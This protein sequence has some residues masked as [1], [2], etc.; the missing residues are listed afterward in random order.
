[1]KGVGLHEAGF[2][3]LVGKNGP[4]ALYAEPE[5]SLSGRPLDIILCQGC[6]DTILRR[7]E[8]YRFG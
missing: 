5:A 2:G 6:R 1:M 7:E 3:Y 8:D 4:P